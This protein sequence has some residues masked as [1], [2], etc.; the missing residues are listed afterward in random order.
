[1]SQIIQLPEVTVKACLENR[2]MGMKFD[3]SVNYKSIL[4]TP[5]SS[6]SDASSLTTSTVRNTPSYSFNGGYNLASEKMEQ[7]NRWNTII[8]N[9]PCGGGN[10]TGTSLTDINGNNQVDLADLTHQLARL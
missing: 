4:Q 10:S 5:T 2:R 1:M 9:Y 8:Y 7:M 3:A 6:Q